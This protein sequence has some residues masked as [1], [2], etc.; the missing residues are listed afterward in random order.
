MNNIPQELAA[1]QEQHSYRY[2]RILQSPQSTEVTIDGK[3]YTSFCSNDYLGL[4]NDGRVCQAAK[5]AINSFGVG[6]GA[7]QLISGYTSVHAKLEKQLAEFFGFEKVVLFSSGYLA[8]LGVISTF[9]NKNTLILEDR[10]NH[11]S[12]IDAAKYT[13]A[14]L[15]RYR[16][17]EYSHAEEIID[18]ETPKSL[19]LASD[20]V[21]SMEGTIASLK[22]LCVLKKRHN[23]FLI[24]D[25]AHG[26]GVLGANG[27]GILEH[28][29][30]DPHNID[31][32][33]GT[34]GKSFGV[35]G[36][37]VCGKTDTI[38]YLIQKARSLIYTTSPPPA[39][40]AASSKSLEIIINEPERRKRL[41]ENIN[42]FHNAVK[43]TGLRLEGTTTAI[44]TIVLGDNQ[45]AN[46]FSQELEKRGILILAI[47][48]PTVPPNTARLRITLC[49]GHTHAQIDRLVTTMSEISS[50]M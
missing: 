9:S 2:R 44:Q 16:H 50:S 4:A 35:S 32:L 26:V 22:K 5:D 12:L 23:G 36:A 11:A 34:L 47:R 18:K 43:H 30:I 3:R 29:S 42:Y 25:D 46:K 14:S 27:K 1:L 20:G 6:S 17:C 21:F 15:K 39:L 31:I 41:Q 49:S 45:K 48:P 8:N 19:L 28:E 7:S 40:M 33:V 10:L 37:Y 13:G 24:I 38:E